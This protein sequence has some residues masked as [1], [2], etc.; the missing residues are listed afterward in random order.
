VDVSR[1]SLGEYYA[2]LNDEELLRL[3]DSGELTPLAAEAAD[4]E[5]RRRGSDVHE[6]PAEEPT[7]E[8]SEEP[9]TISEEI[10]GDLILLGRYI[11]PTKAEIVRG[12]LA[13]DGIFAVVA[14]AHI[15]QMMSA[16]SYA[17]GGV[18][19]LVPES[20]LARAREILKAIEPGERPSPDQTKV[21]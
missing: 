19:V 18:R 2:R 15:S 5:L 3:L 10:S 20:Q 13:A 14:D 6:T 16:M 8:P 12:R 9:A 1:Q 11:S 21:G 17:L 7:T 4:E